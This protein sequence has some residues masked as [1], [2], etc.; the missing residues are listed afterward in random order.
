MN[1]EIAVIVPLDLHLSFLSH[2]FLEAVA[3]DDDVDSVLAHGYI[4]DEE[5]RQPSEF[6]LGHRL[7]DAR[8]T[9]G[10]FP[11]FRHLAR[12]GHE[13]EEVLVRDQPFDEVEHR[14]FD[15]RA[16]DVLQF[17]RLGLVLVRRIA[18][19]VVERLAPLNALAAVGRNHR[20]M[21]VDALDEPLERCRR[22]TSYTL[23]GLL[24]RF[25]DAL[26]V[27]PH[28]ER[29]D[30]VVL[31][32]KD[33]A[34]LRV[35]DAPGRPRLLEQRP[36]VHHVPT[37]VRVMIAEAVVQLVRRLEEGLID[38]IPL[39]GEENLRRV[40]RIDHELAVNVPV[41]VGDD[42]ARPHFFL[43]AG[44]HLVSHTIRRHLALELRE[45]HEKVDD[46]PSH[47]GRGVDLLGNGNHAHVVLGEDA[48][49][50]REVLQ[51]TA[52]AVDLVDDHHVDL[53]VVHVPQKLLEGRARHI[54]ARV[55]AVIVM[56]IDEPPALAGLAMDVRCTG[57][58]LCLQRIELLVEPLVRAFARVDRAPPLTNR[59]LLLLAHFFTPKNAGPFQCVPVIALATA[60]S[61]LYFLPSNSTVVSS[62]TNT[63]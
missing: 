62:T 46:H 26:R 32:L 53:P 23:V 47:R 54:A 61:D 36:Y 15:G 7:D 11:Q 48:V 24:A 25:D 63:S 13:T 40:L 38:H 31:S 21:A 17:A 60:V 30:G 45:A 50:F 55:P 3:T 2:E 57:V 6:G 59:L 51:R 27:Q 43:A 44:G 20:A 35:A 12:V 4:S 9:S 33:L 14:L 49:E 56:L 5:L 34:R 37:C 16:G 42:P 18:P 10:E 52:D 29:H 1:E 8:L 19:V 39:E 41:A 58:E 22:L 28:V